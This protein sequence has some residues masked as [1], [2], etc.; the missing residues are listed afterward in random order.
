METESSAPGRAWS[1]SQ[2]AAPP[3][4]ERTLPPDRIS[5]PRSSRNS[6]TFPEVS[7]AA[8]T[9]S[10]ASLV[11]PKIGVKRMSSLSSVHVTS[12]FGSSVGRSPPTPPQLRIKPG[13]LFMPSTILLA[14]SEAVTI[15][16]EERVATYAPFPVSVGRMRLVFP[17]TASLTGSPSTTEMPARS[18][19]VPSSSSTTKYPPFTPAREPVRS[20]MSV[21]VFLPG[22]ISVASSGT[23]VPPNLFGSTSSTFT[24][25]GPVVSPP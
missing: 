9:P 7:S 8:S 14:P 3:V 1:R 12:C 4:P 20:E 17:L 24:T 10:P 22:T 21:T 11:S 15:C 16:S 13:F 19:G 25:Q 18:P 5:P 6:V 2:F 23:R